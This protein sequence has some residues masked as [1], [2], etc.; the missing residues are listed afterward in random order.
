MLDLLSNAEVWNKV[1]TLLVSIVALITAVITFRKSRAEKSEA[2]AGSPVKLRSFRAIERSPVWSRLATPVL[3]VLMVLSAISFFIPSV[4]ALYTEPSVGTAFLFVFSII[5][6]SIYV[7]LFLRRLRKLAPSKEA[8]LN[9]QGNCEQVLD[10]CIAASKKLKLRLTAI[11][12]KDGMIEG[13][14]RRNWRSWGETIIIRVAQTDQNE[15]AVHIKSRCRQL[16][17][18][19]DW[20]KNAANINR[21]FEELIH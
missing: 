8:T 11:D 16:G 3:G 15:C 19:V 7:V 13:R 21:F 18:L 14:T 9:V 20:G 2:A 10:A 1:L 6:V 12:A 5:C 4:F 17:V